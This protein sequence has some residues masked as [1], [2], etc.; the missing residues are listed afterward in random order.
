MDDLTTKILIL[1]L[2]FLFGILGT[3]IL[4]INNEKRKKNAIRDLIR[5]EIEAF[6][7][8]CKDAEENNLWDSC[9]VE[10][11][12]GHIVR[13]YSQDCERFISVS[14]SKTRQGIIEFYLE[15]SALLSL[16]EIHRNSKNSEKE[17]DGSSAAIGPGLYEKTVKLSKKLL[18]KI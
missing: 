9:A 13:S 12:A 4:S 3:I 5:T 7:R 17:K 11:L 10:T 6:I 18:T 8:A 2:G 1:I 16:I 15:A 14:N